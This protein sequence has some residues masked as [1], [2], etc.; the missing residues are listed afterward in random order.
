MFWIYNKKQV[1][2]KI[3]NNKIEFDIRD[4]LSDKQRR[5]LFAIYFLADSSKYEDVITYENGV[6]FDEI[7][8]ELKRNKL[9]NYSDNELEDIIKG[10][11]NQ[12]YPLLSINENKEICIT[13]IF[14]KM[15]E[16]QDGT[17]YTQDSVLSSLLPNFLCNGGNGYSPHDIADVFEA[18]N[19]YIN[20][21]EISDEEIH[22]ILKDKSDKDLKNIV[23]AFVNHRINVLGRINRIEY[24]LYDEMFRILK[25]GSEEDEKKLGFHLSIEEYEQLKKE[26]TVKYG[27]INKELIE[28]QRQLLEKDALVNC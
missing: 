7:K 8:N 16:G 24:D 20:N 13:R 18:I 12:N 2:T 21:R 25:F 15:F 19:R 27:N 28:E 23:E 11:A 3:I 17:D 22:K 10:F 1:S 5:I 6:N 9:N 14:D 4:G 26:Q